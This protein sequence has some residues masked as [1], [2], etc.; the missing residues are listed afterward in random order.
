[1]SSNIATAA[2]NNLV[3][4]GTIAGD[5]HFHPTADR[6]QGPRQLPAVPRGFTGRDDLLADLDDVLDETTRDQP[7]TVPLAVVYGMAGVGKTTLALRWAHQVAADFPDGQLYIDLCGYGAYRPVSPCEALARFLRAMGT[8]AELMPSRLPERSAQ[9]RSLLSGRR[10]LLL[11][12]NASDEQQVR[13]LLP[14]SSS[15]A[16]IVTSRTELTG[17]VI[18]QGAAPIPVDVLRA[19]EAL[20]MLCTLTGRRV[21]TEPDAAAALARQCARLPL[22]LRIVAGLI[23]CHPT[24]PLVELVESLADERTRLDTLAASGDPHTAVRTVFSWSYQQ[25]PPDAAA[26]FRLIALTPGRSTD[27]YAVAALAG[28]PTD[29]ANPLT[30]A[31]LRAQVLREP[32]HGRIEMHDL[33]RTYAAEL[34]NQEDDESVRRAALARVFDYYLHTAERADHV[35]SPNRF[36]VPLAGTPHPGPRIETHQQALTWIDAERSAL[37]ALFGID[38][39]EL[40][41]QRWQLAYTLRGYFFLT[42]DWDA[43]TQTHQLALA[44]AERLDDITAQASTHNNLGLALLEHGDHAAAAP[45]YQRAQE[46]FERVGDL[47]GASN[48]M[49]NYAWILHDRGDDLAALEIAARALDNYRACGARTNTAITLRGIAVFEAALGRFADAVDHLEQAMAAFTQLG[50]DLN[51]A[52]AL[53]CL[54]EIHGEAGDPAASDRAHRRALALSREQGSQFE[55]ARAHTGLGCAAAALG[56]TAL[57]ESEWQQALDIYTRLSAVEATDVAQN[58]ARLRGGR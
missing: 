21:R 6:D 22:A 19:D 36:R 30:S 48:A 39:P 44:A 57:A 10:V 2:A 5:V 53:N 20:A 34:L 26:L 49:G 51:M 45:H 17:L 40:D 55:Q 13:P 38:D 41:A 54:G 35:L 42:K 15:C 3:Q 37:V 9:F 32:I 47:R 50:S 29:V 23:R 16:V 43:W 1:M 28:V 33:V 31:L 46:L 18:D 12:D 8:P 11:L 24:L 58:L 7:G 25:L 52:M 56:N 4:A 14:G 27:R